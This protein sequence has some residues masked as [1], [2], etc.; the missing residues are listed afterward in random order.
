MLHA[1]DVTGSLMQVGTLAHMVE[2][3]HLVQHNRNADVVT[4][5]SCTAQCGSL[6]LP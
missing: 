6:Q 3:Q 4:V 2:K 1:F 5:A